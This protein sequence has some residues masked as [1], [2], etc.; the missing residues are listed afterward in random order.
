MLFK[1]SIVSLFVFTLSSCTTQSSKVQ[2]YRYHENAKQKPIAALV[3]LILKD[4]NQKISWDVTQEITSQVQK[5]LVNRSKVYLNPV[6][7]SDHLKNKIK[8]SDL[9]SLQKQDLQEL[10]AQNEFVIFMELI[11]HK[12]LSASQFD[13]IVAV[14]VEEE[15]VKYLSVKVRLRVFD[16][17]PEEPKVLLQEILTYK[18]FIPHVERD[19]DYSKVVWGGDSYSASLYGRVHTKLERDLARQI[20]RYISISK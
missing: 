12:E 8:S 18:Q 2:S 17:R 9:V 19:I 10:K 14:D 11:E 7:L 13:E 5:R 3:P 16:L 4:Q 6:Y 15:T 20:E 1:F